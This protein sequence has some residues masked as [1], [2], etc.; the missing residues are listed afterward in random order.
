VSSETHHQRR[1]Q[2]LPT[3]LSHNY[4]SSAT[5]RPVPSRRLTAHTLSTVSL[6]VYTTGIRFYEVGRHCGDHIDTLHTL[7]KRVR[8]VRRHLRPFANSQHRSLRR[9]HRR[10]GWL[11]H[12]IVDLGLFR[13]TIFHVHRLRQISIRRR[14]GFGA[15]WNRLS[16]LLDDLQQATDY[17]AA[18]IP[19]S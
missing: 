4:P 18:R 14:G 8:I 16:R 19:S 7:S 3:P 6:R 1:Q 15:L 11:H 10:A 12:S 13:E 17:F 2:H 9:L 5:E